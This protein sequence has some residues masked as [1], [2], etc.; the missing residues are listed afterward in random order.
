MPLFS[1][2]IPTY[3]SANILKFTLDSLLVQTIGVDKFEV[4]IVDDGSS[5]NTQQVVESYADKLSIQ[6]FY[7]S[8]Q[9]FRVAK[10][11]NTGIDNANGEY[12]LF[13][14]S[15]V[16]VEKDLIS[17]HYQ[18]HQTGSNDIYIGF[19]YG[20]EEY[21]VS[22]NHFESLLKQGEFEQLFSQV[23]AKPE[24]SDCRKKLLLDIGHYRGFEQYPWLMFWGGHASCAKATLTAVAGFDENFVRWGGEDVELGLRL[25]LNGCTFALLEDAGAYHTLHPKAETAGEATA[26][27]NCVYINDKHRLDITHRMLNENWDQIIHAVN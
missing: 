20:F 18:A 25:H 19:C 3:N 4:I 27:N 23:R 17:Q 2:I 24:T 7:Q 9:G 16:V 12:I 5:D 22:N 13:I 21:A 15:G 14:D 26:S 11:R 1:L 10:A 8:D 6:Y